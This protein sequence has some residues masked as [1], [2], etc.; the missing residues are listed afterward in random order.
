MCGVDAHQRLPS[1]R[2]SG[3]L[4]D[5][6]E[7]QRVVDA[8]TPCPSRSRNV[9]RI[10]R[11]VVEQVREACVGAGL[12][13]RGEQVRLVPFGG[14]AARAVCS[15]RRGRSAAGEGTPFQCER[16]MVTDTSSLDRRRL[17]VLP[18]AR[19]GRAVG[20]Q[21]PDVIAM[22]RPVVQVRRRRQA[23]EGAELVDQVWLVREAAVG[24]DGRPVVGGA[25]VGEGD[26]ALEAA[27]ATEA[28][29][30]EADLRG[31]AVDEVTCADAGGLDGIAAPWSRRGGARTRRARRRLPDAGRWS[32]HCSASAASSTSSP[33]IRRAC[34]EQA[35]CAGGR[36]RG[37]PTTRRAARRSRRTRRRV[38][39]ASD[40]KPTRR[41]ARADDVVLLVGV[42][43]AVAGAGAAEQ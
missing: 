23:G 32:R 35:C 16:S 18:C 8:D 31:E 28:L 26:G 1:L 13:G 15:V 34:L 6:G 2:A 41:D 33:C 3:G 29:R 42:D 30:R 7:E 27:D 19:Y 11:H 37:R 12:D 22:G 5:D 40:G 38:V 17:P 4:V 9:L 25:A 43:D 10:G 21:E 20:V 36:W 24:G 14:R 39:A